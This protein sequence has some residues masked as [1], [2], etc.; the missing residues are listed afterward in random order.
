MGFIFDRKCYAIL[1]DK[2]CQSAGNN[3][4]L[5]GEETNCP[6][7]ITISLITLN[8]IHDAIEKTNLGL[9]LDNIHLNRVKFTV[10]IP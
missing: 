3:V 2:T 9:G 8:N 5:G 7:M 6:N 1:D 10:K 4:A